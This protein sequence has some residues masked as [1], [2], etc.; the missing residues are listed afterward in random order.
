[1]TTIAEWTPVKSVTRFDRRIF[2]V[3]ERESE[4]SLTGVRAPFFVIDCQD[5]VNVLPLTES[6]DVVFIEQFRPG[7]GERTVEIPG[8]M[9]DGNET[10]HF[11]A[12]RELLEETGFEAREL[13][14]L[15]RSRPNPAIQNNWLYHLLATGCVKT[16]EARPDEN[17]SIAVKLKPVSRVLE[18][19]A[20]GGIDHSLVLACLFRYER[21]LADSVK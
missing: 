21:L 20:K 11:C 18:M 8:G 12:R 13:V 7:T 15:G 19:A 5:W 14:P 9:V 6:N 10:P 3:E 16:G 1:M 4:N 2:T 17:K